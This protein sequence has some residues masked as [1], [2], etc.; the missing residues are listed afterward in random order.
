MKAKN[1]FGPV[2]G[3]GVAALLLVGVTGCASTGGKPTTRVYEER[4]Y[5]QLHHLADTSAMSQQTSEAVGMACSDCK[6]VRSTRQDALPTE[7][8]VKQ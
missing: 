2:L 4:K 1:H 3:L 5:I 6:T 8:M 7:G